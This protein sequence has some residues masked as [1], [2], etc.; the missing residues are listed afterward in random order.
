MSSFYGEKTKDIWQKL[1]REAASWHRSYDDD[2]KLALKKWSFLTFHCTYTVANP[3]DDKDNL[4]YELISNGQLLYLSPEIAVAER[5]SIKKM[6]GELFIDNERKEVFFDGN[7][8]KGFHGLNYS[9]L[10]HFIMNEGV[11]GNKEK[12]YGEIWDDITGYDYE[13]K[14]DRVIDTAISRFRDI[15]TDNN[16]GTVSLRKEGV[17]GHNK[18]YILDPMPNYSFLKKIISGK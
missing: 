5:D 18:V 7:Y 11:G 13:K 6:K 15:L 8:I 12:I 1:P 17:H 14:T 3:D 9:M 10:R 16:I 4:G 2:R